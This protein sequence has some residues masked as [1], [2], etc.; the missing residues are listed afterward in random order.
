MARF[1]PVL[2]K[3]CNQILPMFQVSFPGDSQSLCRIPRLRSLMWCLE[4][5][6]QCENSLWYDCCPLCELLAWRL[7]GRSAGPMVGLMAASSRRPY[8]TSCASQD[9]CCQCPSLRPAISDPHL[10]RRPSNPH[11]QFWLSLLWGSLLLLP[12]LFILTLFVI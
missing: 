3:F 1:L 2:W 4:P 11:R 7:Y 10:C 8:A 5:C 12:F 6:Q 9:C